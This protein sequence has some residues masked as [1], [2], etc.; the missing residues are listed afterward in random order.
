[1]SV[2]RLLVSRYIFRMT[3]VSVLGST[4]LTEAGDL[5]T[6]EWD[7]NIGQPGMNHWVYCMTAR[8]HHGVDEL[9]VGG[10]FS[11]AGG[12]PINGVA[13]WDGSQWHGFGDGLNE[14]V[15]ALQWFDAGD[16]PV[17]YAGGAFGFSG[18]RP[19]ANM[20]R[21]NEAEQI[22][23]EFGGGLDGAV[24][25]LTIFDD[26]SGPALY[27]GGTFGQAGGRPASNLARWDGES[28]SSVAGPFNGSVRAF[29]EYDDG[30]GPSLY[31]GGNFSIANGQPAGRIIR[32]DG[33][34]W[35]TLGSG[36]TGLGIRSMDVFDDG[37]GPRLYVGGVLETAGGQ[38][39]DH[40]ASWDFQ[41]KIWH[42][43]PGV[44]ERVVNM[45]TFDDGN[46]E[47]LYI[48][49][50]FDL[51]GGRPMNRIGAWNGSE[52]E[53]LGEGA[54]MV[55]RS[56]QPL[57]DGSGLALMVGGG[58]TAIDGH[59][60]GAI[61][62][63]RACNPDLIGD[64]NGD[65]VIDVSDLLLLLAAWGQCPSRMDCPADLNGDGEVD[66]DDLLLLLNHWQ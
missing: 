44:N 20:A 7:V 11:V 18:N 35:E 47:R 66:V 55:V 53:S 48:G 19:V 60:A 24:I 33:E 54:N 65:G 34:H 63:W 52:W 17:L 57:D 59:E 62:Q 39:V 2:R 38:P 8:H 58:F 50:W 64:V 26:G 28:W 40:L 14:R 56:L 23:E 13:M 1:M 15:L 49:G 51:A 36:V 41:S 21:W 6:A 32:W 29:V 16:G 45:R 12:R 10:S 25:A 22:W 42:V 61:A 3:I 5:C 27:A 31:I 43:M 30:T 4:P 9:Y 37:T 46:G